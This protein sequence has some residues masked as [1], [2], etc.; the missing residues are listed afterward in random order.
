MGIEPRLGNS[1]DFAMKL[2]KALI[3]P[4]IENQPLVGLNRKILDKMTMTLGKDIKPHIPEIPK[5]MDN[6]P[7]QIQDKVRK[8]C[9]ICTS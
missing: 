4:H 5:E 6:F 8:R 1:F 9:K 3:I 7:S 2:V